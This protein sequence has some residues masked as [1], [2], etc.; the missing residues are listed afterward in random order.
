MKTNTLLLTLFLS[1]SSM[2]AWAACYDKTKAPSVNYTTCKQAAEQGTAM[3][4]YHLGQMYRDGDGV[5]KN[6]QEAATWYRKAAE[7]GNMLAQY[8]LAWMYDSGEG[9]PQDLV[10]AIKWYGKAA[11]QGDKYA[12]FN[13]GTMYYTGDGAPKDFVKTHFWFDIG[14]LNGNPKAKKWRDKIAKRMS[15]EQIAEAQRLLDEWRGKQDKPVN[16]NK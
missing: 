7:Q 6:P 2:N 14:I 10:E 13:L 11:E 4:Q 5:A 15:P 16:E 1:L 8:N 12:P 9:I 3:S